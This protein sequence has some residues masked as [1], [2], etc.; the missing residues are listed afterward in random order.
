[1]TAGNWIGRVVRQKTRQNNAAKNAAKNMLAKGT[2][3]QLTQGQYSKAPSIVI[4]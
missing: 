4:L 2:L 1:M 3:N